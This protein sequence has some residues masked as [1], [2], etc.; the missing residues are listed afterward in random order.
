MRIYSLSLNNSVQNETRESDQLKTV[1][2]LYDM[3]THQKISMPN[4][5]KL[6]TMAKRSIDQNLQLRNFDA[7]NEKIETGAVVTSRRGLNGVQRGQRVCY[8]WKAKRPVFERRP[9]QNRSILWANTKRLKC[10]EKKEHQRQKP[11]WE[12]QPTAVQKL[13]E[14][15]LH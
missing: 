7:S 4:Y 1:L 11:V 9:M 5:Q 10:V 6:K 3:E 15:Y 13:L 12:V 14:R 2:E 8:Q